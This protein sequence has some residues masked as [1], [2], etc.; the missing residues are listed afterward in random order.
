MK[1]LISNVNK[2]SLLLFFTIT[3][4]LQLSFNYNFF[5]AAS[6]SFFQNH[7]KDSEA[8]VIGKIIDS[9][10][11]GIFN[12]KVLGRY[13]EEI[14][15]N[16]DF[17]INDKMPSNKISQYHSSFGFQ[18][19][20]YSSIDKLLSFFNLS[21]KNKLDIMYF[22][23]SLAMSL[24]FTVF[25]MLVK[26]EFGIF[27]AIL[28][29][30]GIVYSQWL[31]VFA[32]NLYWMTFLLFLPFVYIWYALKKEENSISEN[33]P[34]QFYGFI[35]LIIY[36]KSLAGFEYL[37]TIF[38]SLAIPFFYFYFKNS[39]KFKQLLKRLFFLY[40]SAFIAFFASIFTFLL[41][42]YFIAHLKKPSYQYYLHKY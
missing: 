33:L 28:L 41:Q 36:I 7:Q 37:S 20:L 16:Y 14:Q 40:C 34:K 5:N 11:N 18:G 35:F 29:L 26:R 8:L 2:K 17:Y 19:Y 1:S 23:T 6:S 30:I 32:K 12:E 13:A 24:T 3:F 25:I 4:L 10:S 31:V 38:I 21:S 39:W 9:R 42:K 27:S 22:L 15:E